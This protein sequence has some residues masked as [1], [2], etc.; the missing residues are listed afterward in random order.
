MTLIESIKNLLKEEDKELI[1][2]LD[3]NKTNEENI[4]MLVGLGIL[5]FENNEN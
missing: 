3:F 5:N 4:A 1:E 2:K